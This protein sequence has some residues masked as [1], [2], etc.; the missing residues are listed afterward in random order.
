MSIHRSQ[1]HLNSAIPHTALSNGLIPIGFG[2]GNV[3]DVLN[4]FE[5]PTLHSSSWVSIWRYVK[6][7]RTMKTPD[8]GQF[9]AQHNIDAVSD[10][11]RHVI[12]REGL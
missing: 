5:I 12:E 9:R 4:R 10:A 11:L 1:S 7:V 2:P 3:G 8:F 6:H